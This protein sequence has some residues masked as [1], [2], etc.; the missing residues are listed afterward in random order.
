MPADSP[1]SLLDPAALKRLREM[2]GGDH[3]F[4]AEMVDT[5]LADAPGMFVELGKAL[6]GGDA[7]TFRR[8]AHSLKS[9]SRDFGALDLSEISRQLEM[10]GKEGDLAG[11]AEKLSL[12]KAEYEKTSEPLRALR[13]A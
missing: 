3:A 10:M 2:A 8:V 6:S 12:A 11:A 4:I 1:L 5:F 13:Q 9:N 7:A